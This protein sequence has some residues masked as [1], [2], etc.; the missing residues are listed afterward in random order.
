MRE[1]EKALEVMIV[2]E[3]VQVATADKGGKPNYY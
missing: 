2:K 3:F 1:I